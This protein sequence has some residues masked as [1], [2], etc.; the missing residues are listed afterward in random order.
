MDIYIFG[1]IRNDFD[2]EIYSITEVSDETREVLNLVNS[3]GMY[4]TAQPLIFDDLESGAEDFVSDL[5]TN[6]YKKGCIFLFEK[7]MEKFLE[8]LQKQFIYSTEKPDIFFCRE[9]PYS[10]PLYVQNDDIDEDGLTLIV[11]LD[12]VETVNQIHIS[13][14]R[15]RCRNPSN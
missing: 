2:D 8:E 13:A 14:L 7:D 15:D 9:G 10:V 6:G 4:S 12:S 11:D 3:E 5:Y 1:V